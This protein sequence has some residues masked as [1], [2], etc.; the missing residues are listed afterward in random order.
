[1]VQDLNKQKKKKKKEDYFCYFG[2]GGG[3]QWRR[4]KVMKRGDDRDDLSGRRLI[5]ISGSAVV[6]AFA[7]VIREDQ[8]IRVDS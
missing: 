6:E 1:M 4:L 3:D 5:D 7:G 2:L 8:C